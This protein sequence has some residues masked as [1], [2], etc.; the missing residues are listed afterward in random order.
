MAHPLLELALPPILIEDGIEE[1]PLIEPGVGV[2]NRGGDDA[3]RLVVEEVLQQEALV[4]H[5]G[6][7]RTDPEGA[8]RALVRAD[9]VCGGGGPALSGTVD[10]TS[11]RVAPSPERA[12]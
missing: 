10:T 11:A 4:C 6:N 12:M 5:P 8:K 1:R 9:V 2:G 3:D 7:A